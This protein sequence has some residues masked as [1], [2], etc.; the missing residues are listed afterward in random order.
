[1]RIVTTAALLA[2]L[3]LSTTSASAGT[4]HW[5]CTGEG[6]KSWTSSADLLDAK[7]WA[8]SGDRTTY[9]DAGHCAKS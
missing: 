3:A 2:V 4:G 9:K 1:M 8:Y 5:Y 6:I 7:G